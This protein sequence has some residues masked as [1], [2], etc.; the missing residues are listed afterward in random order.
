LGFQKIILKLFLNFSFPLPVDVSAL[1]AAIEEMKS[2][3]EGEPGGTLTNTA[4][5]LISNFGGIDHEVG[6]EEQLGT[7]AA[8]IT[9]IGVELCAM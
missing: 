4:I 7:L 1:L 3:A 5:T 2:Y 9:Q 8:A 6:F